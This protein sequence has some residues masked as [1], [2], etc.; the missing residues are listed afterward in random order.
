M[1]DFA[2][3]YQEM[4]EQTATMAKKF[5]P[6]AAKMFSP[7]AFE[8]MMPGMGQSFLETFFGNTVNVNG[9][10]AKTRFLVTIAGLSSQPILQDTPLRLAIESARIAGAKKQEITEVIVQMSMFGGMAQTTQALNLALEV[11][12]EEDGKEA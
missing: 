6:D 12:K 2:K 7:K 3:M 1:S 11:F 8:A 9:L 10:D 4:L 5:A